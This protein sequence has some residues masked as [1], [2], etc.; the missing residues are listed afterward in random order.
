MADETE[1]TSKPASNE[2]EEHSKPAADA[3]EENSTNKLFNEIKI[4]RASLGRLTPAQADQTRRHNIKIPLPDDPVI[5]QADLMIANGR[6]GHGL[7]LEDMQDVHEDLI[8]VKKLHYLLVIEAISEAVNEILHENAGSEK[9]PQTAPEKPDDEDEVQVTHVTIAQPKD[10]SKLSKSESDRLAK[11]GS[12]DQTLGEGDVQRTAKVL[13]QAFISNDVIKAEEVFKDIF[14][15]CSNRLSISGDTAGG[16]LEEV[17][18]PGSQAT[19]QVSTSFTSTPDD[20]VMMVSTK[21]KTPLKP[22]VY[23]SQSVASSDFLIIAARGENLS[24]EQQRD[25]Q[26][27]S[28]QLLMSSDCDKLSASYAGVLVFEKEGSL[29]TVTPTPSVF[30]NMKER[31]MAQAIAFANTLKAAKSFIKEK[32]GTLS[33]QKLQ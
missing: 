7:T 31:A 9:A 22:P 15:K 19:G 23:D 4:V 17:F 11:L 12:F 10:L 21:T 25:F 5:A 27:E 24:N 16:A 14:S 2:T 33:K 1:E 30:V 20:E 6:R 28:M 29:L 32:G 26:N 8:V 3:T 18:S 13:I